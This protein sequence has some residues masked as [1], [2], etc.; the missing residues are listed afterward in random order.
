[1]VNAAASR[2]PLRVAALSHRYG[3]RQVLHG[4]DLKVEPGEVVGLLG[5]N[6]AG[7]TT[8]LELIEGIQI[9]S[10]GEVQVYGHAPRDMPADKRALVGLIF[11]RNALPDH[12]T[13]GQMIVLCQRVYGDGTHADSLVGSLG[14][15]HLVP[16]LVG[17]LS[18]GQK[19]RLAVFCAL[20]S[21]PSFVVMDEPTSALDLR[22]RRAVWD[23]ILAA[24]RDRNLSGL[25]ATHDM[26]EAAAL[27]DRVCFI[28]DGRLRGSMSTDMAHAQVSSL[29][30][31]FRAPD[32]FLRDCEALS[33]HTLHRDPGNDGYR[34]DCVKEC[35]PSVVEALLAG[36]KAYDFDAAILVG[37]LA[38]ERAYYEHVS[39]AE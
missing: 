34:I 18:V 14:L 28:E 21:S 3:E 17:E 5:P 25:I 16:R 22:S 6:G 39:T 36:E 7:K 19:Q 2:M 9:P 33:A 32:R 15:T 29:V 26:E 38:L 23:V 31:R 35:V 1:M 27:C 13:V 10:L 8:L 20:A 30:V 4:L 24:K 12:V 11:Q 37:Q